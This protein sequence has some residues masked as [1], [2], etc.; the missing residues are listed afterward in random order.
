MDKCSVSKI[1]A[2]VLVFIL[3]MGIVPFTAPMTAV[4]STSGS[5]PTISA[6][7]CEECGLY[8]CE[9]C[10]ICEKYP[11]ECCPE[12]EKYPCEC[13]ASCEQCG[14]YP[15]ECC[16]Y[17]EQY[18][19]ICPD[20]CPE[21]EKFPCECPTSCDV[22]EKYPCVCPCGVCWKYPCECYSY[23][24][25]IDFNSLFGSANEKDTL[26]GP[27]I[28]IL[29]YEAPL[30]L[31]NISLS[32][33]FGDM[34]TGRY[35]A[36]NQTYEVIIGIKTDEATGTPENNDVYWQQQYAEIKQ[37]VNALGRTTNQTFYNNFRR[38]RSK[39]KKRNLNFAFDYDTYCF[40]V[41]KFDMSTGTPRLIEGGVGL[42]AEVKTGL[43]YQFNPCVYARLQLEGSAETG[44]RLVLEDSGQILAKGNMEVSTRLTFSVEASILAAKAYAGISGAL[45]L[46]LALPL[47]SMRESLEVAL[48]ASFFFQWRALL[49]GERYEH[50]F[51][52]LTLYPRE[53]T[54]S[55]LS[56]PLN[57]MEFI[58]PLPPIISAY[59]LTPGVFRENVQVYC[60]P[61]I[62][63]LGNGNMFLAYIED[64]PD[65]SDENR[66]ILMYSVFDGTEWSTPLP[67]LDDGTIDFEPRIFPDGNGGVHIVWQNG[68]TIFNSDT[69]LNEMASEIELHYIHW[70]GSS[71]S[72]SAPITSNNFLEANYKIASSGG[73][74]FVAWQQNSENDPFSLSG[75]NSIY[76]RQ[77]TNG[78]WQSIEVIA[79]ELPIITSMDVTY[80]DDTAMIAY[81]VKTNADLLD[82]NDLELFFYD[83]FA[84]S[85]LTNDDTPDYSASFL[86]NELYWISGRRIM[87]ITDGDMDTMLMVAEELGAGVSEI[88]AVG[89]ADNKAVIWA[90]ESGNG[91]SLFNTRY[92]FADE[93]FGS[94]YPLVADSGIIR[95]WD[96]VMLPSGQIETAYCFAAIGED[97]STGYNGT[98][99]GRLD[100][101]QKTA[102]GFY[103]IFVNPIVAYDGEIAANNEITL[104]V[105]VYNSGSLAINEFDVKISDS[106]ESEVQTL[107]IY[108][109]LPVGG[110]VELEIPFTLPD[111]ILRSEY[112]VEVIPDNA[113]DLFLSDNRGFF[114]FGYADLAFGAIREERTNFGRRLIVS[115]INQGFEAIGTGTFYVLS[116]GVDGEVL[117]IK[118]VEQLA[119]SASIEFTFDIDEN[120]L[121]SSI[122]EAPRLF[123]LLLETPDDE[124]NF[125]NNS[126]VVYVYPDYTIIVT[127][128]EGGTAEGFGKYEYNSTV[129]VSAFPNQGYVFDG[130]LENGY[131]LHNVPSVYEFT[132]NTDRTLTATFRPNDL[133]ITNIEVFGSLKSGEPLIFT[134]LAVDGVYPL[135]WLFS[136]YSGETIHYYDDASS[137]NF[138]EWTPLT[139]GNY[140]VKA[141]CTDSTGQSFEYIVP[142]TVTPNGDYVM[143]NFVVGDDVQII[144]GE[145][146]QIVPQ[147]GEAVTPV[148]YRKGWVFDE[149]DVSVENVTSDTTV[150]PIWLR[151]GNVSMG[152]RGNVTSGDVVWLARHIAGHAGFD[153]VDERIADINGDEVVDAGDI[154]A[155]L[156]WLV[157]YELD[158][159][160]V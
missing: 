43:S 9:C 68:T 104:F 92:S 24:Y 81:T 105:D 112:T 97:E 119:P 17:C 3:L 117:D 103:D 71:F 77:F 58:P 118:T 150:A 47:I 60:D 59:S 152:G 23:E 15:C 45:Q 106:A 19:C 116:E 40:G 126:E 6:Y 86:G 61:Q 32:T 146:V 157:G 107:T 18:P 108:Q 54:L 65:R 4:A 33:P 8:P 35:D 66:A 27:N 31:L 153:S 62:T 102:S 76:L 14:L 110:A 145:P 148:V 69:T 139:A 78:A 101:M 94:A 124:S 123:F 5:T 132:A 42:I 140:S 87:S 29:G 20:S 88:K 158:E 121:D 120:D 122:S 131:V 99:Y 25:G 11:C 80:I 73:N 38:M 136:V 70:N 109:Y 21:C 93:I 52:D 85:R 34:A 129:T 151:L 37:L 26:H 64:S 72:N 96:A 159:L 113:N 48:N 12:C 74:I 10:E 57:E 89:E 44:L 46:S 1:S 115:V 7:F 30:F 84:T 41:A 135:Q 160:R 51:L 53:N 147:G 63:S 55:A 91:T 22:C 16:P 50:V 75:T 56:I 137:L 83:G 125:G 141:S 98:P 127:A 156:R 130:W 2:W 13:P 36:E 155:L 128:D 111:V 90:E 142:F 133:E 100:L 39:L 67:V 49:W 154:T 28:N 134:A 143:V 149:W 82:V 144:S 138:F 79:S 95:G 114:T